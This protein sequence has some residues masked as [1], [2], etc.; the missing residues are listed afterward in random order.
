MAEQFVV[1]DIR[2]GKKVQ[3]H[4]ALIKNGWNLLS[5]DLVL[6]DSNMNIKVGIPTIKLWSDVIGKLNVDKNYITK[7]RTNLKN[8]F[9]Y[10]DYIR[11]A[12]KETKLERIYKLNSAL[13]N[14]SDDKRIQKID[15]QKDIFL[16]L[17]D[18]SFKPRIIRGSKF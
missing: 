17:R 10:F 7:V 4:T 11:V 15:N 14:I 12:E 18:N 6:I 16:Y 8:I 3:L 5:D 9:R 2:V 1:L 13:S